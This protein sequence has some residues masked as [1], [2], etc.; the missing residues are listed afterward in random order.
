M[1]SFKKKKKWQ[2][3]ILSKCNYGIMSKRRNK[4]TKKMQSFLLADVLNMNENLFNAKRY[5]NLNIF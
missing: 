2:I 1:F 5:L 4:L 3:K